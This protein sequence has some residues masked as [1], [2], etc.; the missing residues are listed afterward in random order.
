MDSDTFEQERLEYFRSNGFECESRWLTGRGERK[1]YA[2]TSPTPGSPTTVLIHGGLSQGSEWATL[3]NRL[4]GRVVVVDRPGC[5]LSFPIDYRDV[6]FRGA[7]VEWM[8]EVV[9]ALDEEPVD[10]VGNSMGGFFAIVFAIA[11]PHRVRR[12]V[13]LGAPA[14]LHRQ[15]PLFLRLW[16]NPITGQLIRRLKIKDPEQLRRRVFAQLLVSKPEQVSRRELELAFAAAGLPGAAVGGFSLLRS[17]TTLRGWRSD[18]SLDDEI[19]DLDV[20]TLFVWADKDA[21]AAPSVGRPSADRMPQAQFET[22]AGAGHLPWLDCPD[23]VTEL[24]TGFLN[25]DH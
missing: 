12:L 9:D 11:H 18:L 5:G 7:A 3:A 4:P 8:N 1:T 17:V 23:A 20:P 14:G 25:T 21:F 16:G 22:L 10:L 6:D 19:A 2:A 24:V 13:L 15:I